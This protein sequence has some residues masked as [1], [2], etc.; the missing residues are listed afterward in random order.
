[1]LR[2]AKFAQELAGQFAQSFDFQV[3]PRATRLVRLIQPIKFGSNASSELASSLLSTT[4]GEERCIPRLVLFQPV[5]EADTLGIV[6]KPVQTQL[7]G[8]CLAKPLPYQFRHFH[9][10]RGGRDRAN[11]PDTCPKQTFP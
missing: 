7:D 9:G 1:M 11:A 5:E 2:Q 8:R 4:G 10:P 3:A 6:A